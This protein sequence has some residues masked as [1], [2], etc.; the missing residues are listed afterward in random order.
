MCGRIQRSFR[1]SLDFDHPI[2]LSYQYFLVLY[3]LSLGW[4]G[5]VTGKNV[6]K[7]V[8]SLFFFDI[9][10]CW[11]GLPSLQ[12]F[13]L[14][15]RHISTICWRSRCL[16][17]WK[18]RFGW[19]GIWCKISRGPWNSPARSGKSQTMMGAP[20]RFT[21]HRRHHH[22]DQFPV[23]FTIYCGEFARGCVILES[24]LV[25]SLMWTQNLTY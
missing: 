19:G 11:F 18:I 5:L 10:V 16:L 14:A 25:I 9:R 13:Q 17:A 7:R 8:C 20:S 23:E 1:S 3:M 15:F 6:I 12:H 24:W 2:I 21:L 22:H 4:H